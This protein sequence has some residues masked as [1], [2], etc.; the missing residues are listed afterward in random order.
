M[1]SVRYQREIV[2]YG[3]EFVTKGKTVAHNS[4]FKNN[5][6]SQADSA[7]TSFRERISRIFLLSIYIKN[8]LN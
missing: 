5:L 6:Q 7:R 4:G 3:P 1:A 8:S 2:T